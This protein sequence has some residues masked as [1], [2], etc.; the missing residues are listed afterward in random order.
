MQVRLYTDLINERLEFNAY[1]SDSSFDIRDLKANQLIALSKCSIAETLFYGNNDFDQSLKAFKNG[2]RERLLSEPVYLFICEHK[3]TKTSK[4]KSY[5]GLIDKAQITNT[6][7]IECEILT[8]KGM[9]VLTVVIKLRLE[10][11]QDYFFDFFLDSS[12][13]FVFI[14]NIYDFEMECNFNQDVVDHCILIQETVEIKYL[15]L[16]LKYCPLGFKFFRVGGDGVG[17]YW[18]LQQFFQYK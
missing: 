9:S 6:K 15:Q 5:K 10:L 14:P 8:D 17:G 18:S 16:M 4:L 3:P 13:S 12:R 2:L 11:L 7:F 1:K